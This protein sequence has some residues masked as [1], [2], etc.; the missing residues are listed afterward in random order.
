[1]IIDDIN[2]YNNI[3]INKKDIYLYIQ[4]KQLEGKAH[5]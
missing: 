1:M 5:N 4:K 3:I 2:I